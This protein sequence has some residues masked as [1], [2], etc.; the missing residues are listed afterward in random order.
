MSENK[1]WLV[2]DGKYS[3]YHVVGVFSTKTN[4][5]RIKTLAAAANDIEELSL[6]PGIEELNAGLTLWL[7]R[8]ERGGGVEHCSQQTID[9]YSFEEEA[10]IWRR[11][12]APAYAGK[13]LPDLLVHTV[14]AK[15]PEHAIK[16]VNEVRLQMIARGE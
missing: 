3:D 6:D 5:E 12:T 1:V 13:N 4:A 9:A 2:T 16:I 7:V 8:M 14:W 15:S 10:R 11:S